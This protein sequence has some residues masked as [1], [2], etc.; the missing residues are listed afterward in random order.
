MAVSPVTAPR[1]VDAQALKNG[2][3]QCS[4]CTTQYAKIATVFNLKK[5]KH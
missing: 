3:G 4:V 5:E 1:R 2:N